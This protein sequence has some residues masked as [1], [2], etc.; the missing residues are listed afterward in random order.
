ME[1]DGLKFKKSD[2]KGKLL[3]KLV[4]HLFPEKSDAE[5][6]DILAK[7]KY[8]R[9]LSEDEKLAKALS[10]N[11][12]LSDAVDMLASLDHDTAQAFPEFNKAQKIR[13][14][15]AF[16]KSLKPVTLPASS[17]SSDTSSS[18]DGDAASDFVVV[19]PVDA[20]E[21]FIEE[22]GSEAV[23][24]LTALSD[25]DLDVL[26]EGSNPPGRIHF[27]SQTQAPSYYQG[28]IM[29][30]AWPEPLHFSIEN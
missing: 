14:S 28:I 6:N 7:H 10:E 22:S 19:E 23:S 27:V 3:D 1:C 25:A 24:D 30:L 12:D 2:S 18:H 8:S 17:S 9:V 4:R 13:R 26:S 20:P 21:E 11:R 29:C 15:P 5:V 16:I